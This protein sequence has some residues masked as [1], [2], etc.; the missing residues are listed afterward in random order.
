VVNQASVG[1]L[2]AAIHYL[3][4]ASGFLFFALYVFVQI[5]RD[6]S[7][8]DRNCGDRRWCCYRQRQ[9][10]CN[11]RG[12]SAEKRSDCKRCGLTRQLAHFGAADTVYQIRSGIGV[13]APQYGPRRGYFVGVSKKF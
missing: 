6:F 9:I 10:G 11:C 5:A 1:P 13:F 8:G 7:T 3:A 2:T 12:R 4:I